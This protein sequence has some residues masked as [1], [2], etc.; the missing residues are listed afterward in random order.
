MRAAVLVFASL[1]IAGA[2]AAQPDIPNLTVSSI[3]DFF[4][5]P[6]PGS[7]TVQRGRTNISVGWGSQGRG[8]YPGYTYTVWAVVFNAPE[9]CVSPDGEGGTMCG[10]DDVFGPLLNGA[11]N[12]AEVDVLYAGGAVADARGVRIEGRIFKGQ[13]PGSVYSVL[14]AESLGLTNPL[15]AEVH[16]VARSHGPL[17]ESQ[18]PEQVTTY[19]GGCLNFIGPPLAPAI[20]NEEGECAD[21]QFSVH[22]SGIR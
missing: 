6:Q 19:A 7:S 22:V 8:I 18:M 14:G 12:L 5:D 13:A 9:K 20:A 2:A 11:P 4:G 1:L 3:Q 10:E 21:T 16:L 15:R 17:V